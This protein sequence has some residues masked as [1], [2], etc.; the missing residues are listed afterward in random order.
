MADIEILVVESTRLLIPGE[1][2]AMP[3]SLLDCTAANFSNA[4]AIWLFQKPTSAFGDEFNLAHHLRESL[5]ITL[6]SYPHW[7]GH[8]KA[9]EGT[10]GLVSS[11]AKQFPPH[12]RRYGRLYAHFGTDNDPGVEYVFAKSSATL[13]SLYPSNRTSQQCFWS[14][15]SSI[16]TKFLASVP[17]SQPLKHSTKNDDGKLHPLLAIQVTMLACGGFVLAMNASHPLADATTSI[18]LL[19]D[20]ASVSRSVLEGRPLPTLSP[21]FDHALIDNHASGDISANEPDEAI[22]RQAE[23]LPMNRY[24]WWV[25]ESAPPWPFAIPEPFATDDLQPTGK[26]MPWTEWDLASPVSNYVIHLSK[27]QVN[28]LSNKANNSA[29]Q[30]LSQHDAIL[31]H[32]WSCIARARG[33]ETDTELIHCDLVYGVRSSFQLDDRFLGSPTVMMSV[34][35]PG[36]EV[37][38]S[39][40]LTQVATQVRTTLKQIADP[41]NLAA[42]LHSVAFE[43]SPQ[44][45][46]QAFLG[47]RHILVTT[48]ARAGVYDIDFGLGSVCSYAEGVVPEMDGIILIKEAPGPRAEYWTDNGVDISIHIKKDDMERLLK[49]PLLFPAVA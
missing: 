46:W 38:D 28:F 19:K 21:T 24:D 41:L 8:L 7:M 16:F 1:E 14:C 33:L 2:K 45:I 23:A 20:W 3:L 25:P 39:S 44:R 22:L 26:A 49:D 10:D 30:K 18:A 36:S 31:G 11:E 43:K 17:I 12:A 34:E 40:N 5:R 29:S 47:R 13:D 27:E 6:R 9:I 32:I 37:S 35:L 42:H 48:W 15:D 4:S